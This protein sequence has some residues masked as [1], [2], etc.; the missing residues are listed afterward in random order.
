MRAM[1]GDLRADGAAS[2]VRCVPVGGEV[3]EILQQQVAMLG[4]DAFGMELHAVHRQ[5]LMHQA[6]DQAVVGLRGDGQ[7]APACSRA[8]PSA[9]D[10]AS[11]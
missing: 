8:R 6:H 3:E 4:G 10:S 7:F 1:R 2:A 9:N 11:P 5:A